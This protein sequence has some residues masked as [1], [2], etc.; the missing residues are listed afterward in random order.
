[1]DSFSAPIYMFNETIR[2][3]TQTRSLHNVRFIRKDKWNVII[4][5]EAD[6]ETKS[7]GANIIRLLGLA[8]VDQTSW[9]LCGHIDARTQLHTL[10]AALINKKA[11]DHTPAA[12]LN[13]CEC[14]RH[15]WMRRKVR[16]LLITTEGPALIHAMEPTMEEPA[17]RLETVKL[18]AIIWNLSYSQTMRVPHMPTPRRALRVVGTDAPLFATSWRD[19]Q[20]VWRHSLLSSHG[21]QRQS[22]AKSTET[23]AV[24]LTMRSLSNLSVTLATTPSASAERVITPILNGVFFVIT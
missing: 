18:K 2:C 17:R 14:V 4:L 5:W 11:N 23:D 9:Q 3:S 24:T 8:D 13:K 1:M 6:G 19:S 21:D 16:V 15:R 12:K 10:A 7:L 22:S 20:G